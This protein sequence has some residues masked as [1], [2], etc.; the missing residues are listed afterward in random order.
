MCFVTGIGERFNVAKHDIK[1]YK[2]LYKLFNG[3]YITPYRWVSVQVGKSLSGRVNGHTLEE[4]NSMI[5]KK[6]KI[7][8]DFYAEVEGEKPTNLQILDDEVVHAYTTLEISEYHKKDFYGGLSM[9]VINT[10]WTIPEGV[11]YMVNDNN[12]IVASKMTFNK[13]IK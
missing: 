1:C 12:E 9:T 10:E 6:N 11:F 13:E 3:E 4:A 2:V 8:L 5:V 7:L